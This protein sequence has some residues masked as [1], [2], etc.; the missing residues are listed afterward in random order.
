MLEHGFES[1]DFGNHVIQPSFYVWIDNLSLKQVNWFFQL[2]Q[3]DKATGRTK[4]EF[5]DG[6]VTICM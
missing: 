4:R 5:L 3:L 2:I 6:Q 1:K